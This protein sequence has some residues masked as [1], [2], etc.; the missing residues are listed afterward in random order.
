MPALLLFVTL[1]AL[2]RRSD[3]YSSLCLGAEDGLKVILRIFPALVIL[4]SAISVFRASG[5]QDL[6]I[7]LLTPLFEATGIPPE[8]APLILVRPFSG[9]A[10]LATGSTI[11]DNYGA[12]STIGRTA[13]V[14]LGSSET[15]F[16][17]MA[18]YLSASRTRA[19]RFV[20][21]AALIGEVVGFFI[22]ALSVRLF[23]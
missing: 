23:F 20:L 11:I 7:R 17:T 18:V 12:D 15:L 5:A 13:A 4:L 8:T 9:S 2:G 22:A 14:M 21:P 1:F 10:A 6:L 3:V 16:Y 19:P